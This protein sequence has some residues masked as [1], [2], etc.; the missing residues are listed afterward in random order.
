MFGPKY[1]LCTATHSPQKIIGKEHLRFTVDNRV[2]YHVI[3]LE[4]CGKWFDWLLLID[5]YIIETTSFD[6]LLFLF[7]QINTEPPSDILRQV[8]VYFAHSKNKNKN[9]LD[10]QRG[11][12]F[13]AQAELLSMG[14]KSILRT[15]VGIVVSAKETKALLMNLHE[16]M[17]IYSTIQKTVHSKT[18]PAIPYQS[19]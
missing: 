19:M 13:K 16:V 5:H 3:F 8:S 11:F 4:M 7:L 15:F 1:S 18:S 6:W 10:G 12:S 2:Q 14:W 9:L 17:N